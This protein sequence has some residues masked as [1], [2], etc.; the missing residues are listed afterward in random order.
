M[1]FSTF[2]PFGVSDREVRKR[3]DHRSRVAERLLSARCV[4]RWKI[5]TDEFGNVSWIR[6]TRT[7]CGNLTSGAD[8]EEQYQDRQ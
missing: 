1:G 2:L 8:E 7:V 4:A 5:A 6:V 3:I